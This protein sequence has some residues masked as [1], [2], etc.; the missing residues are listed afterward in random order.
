[1]LSLRRLGVNGYPGEDEVPISN[2]LFQ[3]LVMSNI[4][5]GF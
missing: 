2:P 1:M 4:E 3:L 5:Q